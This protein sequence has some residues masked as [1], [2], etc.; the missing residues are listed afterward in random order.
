MAFID[1][2]IR[3]PAG[4]KA[5]SGGT[6]WPDWA[7]TLAEQGRYTLPDYSLANRQAATMQ[8]VSW[9][10]IAVNA[11]ASYAVVQDIHVKKVTGGREVE[12]EAHPFE[13]MLEQ[14]NPDMSRAELIRATIGSKKLTGNAYWWLNAASE[15][16]APDE[17]WLL[18]S[19]RV[20]PIPDERMYIKGY[21]YEGNTKMVLPPWQVV[22]FRNWHPTL[23]F[24]GLSDIEA[25]AVTVEGDWKMNRW[26][27]DLFAEDNAK[28][29]G[30]LTFASP[31]PDPQWELIK[32]EF[33]DDHGGTRRRLRMLRGVGDG[34][35]NWVQ[36]LMT[37]KDI[38]FLSGRQFNR[39]EILALMAPGLGNMLAINAT[40][41]NAVVGRKTL[42]DMAVW[43]QLVEIAAK[44][45]SNILPR[46]G[47][48]LRCDFDDP[49]LPDRAMELAEQE[50]FAK[51][52]TIDE[53]RAQFYE[54]NPLGDQRGAMLIAEV[55][56]RTATAPAAEPPAMAQTTDTES[57]TDD[58]DD[59]ATTGVEAKRMKELATWR[60]YALK[61]G[62]E[63]ALRFNP[64]DLTPGLEVVIKAR[65]AAA[66]TAEEV[67]AAFAGPF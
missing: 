13:V 57:A 5:V 53:V 4:S 21:E 34:S 44:I 23:P 22:H 3:R 67:S 32:Q 41:A 51:V 25:L 50:A 18:P 33:K 59:Q 1:K 43:P 2:L 7:R 58:Q 65:L 54:A 60:R 31:I 61:H 66:D 35:V 10:A 40:E 29:P 46:Y 9:V 49:R 56:A 55:G 63:K 14:P 30:V 24:G 27:L 6:Q 37:P 47:Q 8:S 38:E 28:F 45:T 16:A 39:E 48:G 26:N 36:T 42:M 52:H 11:I 64:D 12:V 20:R 62:A 19:D 17:I 15:R